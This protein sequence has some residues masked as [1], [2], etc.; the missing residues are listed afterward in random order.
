V[1]LRHPWSVSG[2]LLT[3]FVFAAGPSREA[4]VTGVD[5][6]FMTGAVCPASLP[7]RWRV[8]PERAISGAEPDVLEPSVTPVPPD[9]SVAVTRQG[10][11]P[12]TW[13]P[14]TG[15]HTAAFTVTN[16]GN[17]D[18]GFR[19]TASAT[20]NITGLSVSP[21]SAGLSHGESITA[22]ITY[23]VTAAGSGTV[24][25]TVTGNL[26]H[27]QG[28]QTY[29][30]VVAP[31]YQV[32]VT[33]DGATG[34]QRSANTTGYTDTFRVTNTGAN[35]DSYT[36]TCTG[37]SVTCTGTTP[38]ITNL[39]SNASQLVTAQYNTGPAGT[40]TLTVT[41]TSANAS[42]QGSYSVPVAAR[43]VAVTP[44]SAATLP[45][46]SQTGGYYAIFTVA[47]R[48]T[49]TDTYALT[50][51]SSTN[52]T[53]T[54]ISLGSVTLATGKDTVDTAFY[55]LGA[56][57][58]GSLTLTATGSR[59]ND[60]GSLI[61]SVVAGS[62]Q[63]AS[64]RV[65]SV[66]PGTT[67]ERRLCLT[68][69]LAPGAAS[70]CGDLRLVHA[71]P[72]TRTQS[73]ARIP[74]LIYNG[75]A[76]HPHPVVAANVT[77]ATGGANPDSVVAT[78]R[79]GS[80]QVARGRWSGAG[81]SAGRPSRIVL[82]FDS[83]GLATGVYTYTVDVVNWYSSGPTTDSAA[84]GSLAVVNR[85]DSPFGAGWWLAGLEHLYFLPDTTIL[86]AGGDGSARQYLQSGTPN[87]WQGPKL[88]R[89]DSITKDGSG[90]WR[91]L[92][93]GLRV[94][95]D[96]A[97][98]H[99]TTI[100]RLGQQTT[101][102]YTAAGD[103]LLS[104]TIP[105]SAPAKTYR[106]WYTAGRLDSVV[107]PKADTARRVTKLT[108]SGGRVTTIRDPDNS[109]VAF[110]YTTGD[111]NRIVSRTDRRLH[112]TYFA[113]DATKKIVKDS[114]DLGGGN[115]IVSRFRPLESLGRSYGVDTSVAYASVDG[116]RTDV[117]DTTSFWLDRYG[118]PRRIR[119]ALGDTTL[120]IRADVA[121]PALVTKTVDP[122]GRITGAVYDD[123][124]NVTAI[125]DSSTFQNGRYATTRYVWNRTWDF[126]S[127]AAPP[128]GDSTVTSYSSANGNRLWQQDA[129]GGASRIN[130]SYYT[131]GNSSS[132]LSAVQT[133]TQLALG[134]RDSV[135]YDTLA[136]VLGTKTPLGFVT[137]S[138]R[139]SLGR[140]TLVTSPIDSVQT[141]FQTKRVQYDLMGHDTLTVDS[142][143]GVTA[144]AQGVAP[145]AVSL[146]AQTVTVRK[147]YDFQGNLDTLAR[148]TDPD[149]N[150]LGWI[151]T[152]WRYDFANRKVAEVAPDD[153]VDSTAYDPAGNAVAL[154]TR[155]G[156]VIPMAYD[157]VNRLTQRIVP[158][159][160][161]SDSITCLPGGFNP[162]PGRFPMYHFG[163][164][165]G[166]TVP[167][168]TATFAYD[169]AG[170]TRRANNRWARISRRYN[171]NGTL[172]TDTLR[173]AAY[174]Q[175][176]AQGDTT[177]H[178]YGLSYGY[179]LNARRIWLKYPGAIA[180]VDTGVVRD[181]AAYAYDVAGQLATLRDIEGNAFQHAYDLDGRLDSL[182]MPGQ[183]FRKHYYD[184]DGRLSRRLEM[185]NGAVP[186]FD[187]T[188]SYDARGRIQQVRA[189]G[190]AAFYN[191][192]SGL[193]ALLRGYRAVGDET[194]E[195][196]LT[197][198]LGNEFKTIEYPLSNDPPT[199]L[200]TYQPGVGRLTL[201][202]GKATS[203]KYRADTSF[204]R[205]DPAGNRY[206]QDNR[207]P[208]TSGNQDL[209]YTY[210]GADQ[211]PRVVERV[212]F[213]QQ[214]FNDAGVWEEYRYD[215]LGRRVLVRAR[216]DSTMGNCG[217]N[218]A[219]CGAVQRN[220]YI[221]RTIWDGDAVL[222]EIRGP[223]GDQ[224][225]AIQL[226]AD[227][228]YVDTVGAPY[229]RTLYTNGA[230]LDHPLGLIH[231]GYS[232]G[233]GG[234]PGFPGPLVIVL[235]N[236]WRGMAQQGTT[237][238]GAD[239]GTVCQSNTQTGAQACL[240]N[241]V[242]VWPG[243][244][245]MTDLRRSYYGTPIPWFG[246]L[247]QQ[248]RDLSQNLYMRNRYF[249]P[250]TGK[251]T[252]EDPI[253]L[254]G[255]MNLYGFANGDP[256]NFT[257]PFGL[258][259]CPA[260]PADCKPGGVTWQRTTRS[261]TLRK[262]ASSLAKQEG[263]HISVQSGDR[264]FVPRGGS[265]NS[266]HLTT[267]LNPSARGAI[268]F[269]AYSASGSQLPDATVASV[270]INSGLAQSAG[271]RLI[272]HGEGTATEGPHMHA[273]TR[274][275]IGNLFETGG[276]YTP[277]AGSS[278]E[279]HLP[280]QSSAMNLFDVKVPK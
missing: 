241:S 254:A 75:A 35:T 3:A 115:A 209:T 72:A 230:D 48:D 84:S 122:N 118:Q 24:T 275:D 244:A 130:F 221:E 208:S 194:D 205:Y 276:T 269:H 99:V 134:T 267:D 240:D 89:P 53:C 233:F 170:N 59:G 251:F 161:Y 126:D 174:G 180:P 119:D 261:E 156:H 56:A 139:D 87:L 152:K 71:L 120:L 114:L 10:V 235:H 217:P 193:G 203:V 215:A 222:A 187:D 259:Q 280:A 16:T 207:R 140:D 182:A 232:F 127:I 31:A 93:H 65:D 192:Y 45:H 262:F 149:T 214:H 144:P 95:F 117:H 199:Y 157:A 43:P 148:R 7:E 51:T 147:H 2:L 44:D 184:P 228:V 160:V 69:A 108:I 88:D 165:G 8:P 42:D 189:T 129:R 29:S 121:W 248:Q 138:Y 60:N 239:I 137:T 178:V 234:L 113:Y 11:S 245:T 265:L 20:G 272:V 73:K 146:P 236:N 159:T 200:Y 216:R 104:I 250:T 105:P 62:P 26:G 125:T 197:D 231:V 18:D 181:S 68:F 263:V 133:P 243:R 260:K 227:A 164:G 49:A 219:W 131:T 92:P 210:F 94:R 74:T 1:V 249:D 223:G 63:P 258:M 154:V 242:N 106:F 39:A 188:L 195:D 79:L 6:R 80:A 279:I 22:T 274:T 15:G 211:K 185:R 46:S 112:T 162:C 97:G 278:P 253:G 150:H 34:V 116:P 179:D 273:D 40:G 166:M 176:T 66:N 124:G 36:I 177:T 109:S 12:V 256:V 23:S 85:K 14:N 201:I 246:N 143:P 28:I 151:T 103:T 135:F 257:D 153:R 38:S 169:S 252:Q 175:F 37:S 27:E 196:K 142:G 58:A 266:E 229:G 224:T 107:A 86:W 30:V 96:L 123:H 9:Y 25:L 5:P 4:R 270:A 204:S 67:L 167:A 206:W 225:S 33:P 82:D 78:L 54:R 41:A 132:L 83:L 110:G 212:T 98:R 218:N 57:G 202:A 172:A 76:A 247:I 136:N 237:P 168:D 21:T 47:N 220:S 17:C 13:P 81:W 64:V 158:S 171:R 61:I 183:I 55:S 111:T 264:N 102:T 70:E 191:W 213:G 100:N 91:Y 173:I 238:S 277:W 271:V 255:G 141:V 77:L 90:Y 226:E 32:S 268:D 101:F 52:V 145:F 190:G 163:P 19:L 155:R 198:G 128:E 186:L 50:C